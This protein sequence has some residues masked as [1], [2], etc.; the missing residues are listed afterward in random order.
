MY[1]APGLRTRFGG[2]WGGGVW[3]GVGRGVE[4]LKCGGV[5]EPLC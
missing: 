4:G 3:G 2:R 1:L 5:A